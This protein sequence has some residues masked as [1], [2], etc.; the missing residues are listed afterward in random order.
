MG[1]TRSRIRAGA[2]VALVGLFVALAV[3]Q[4]RA[5]Q[6]TATFGSDH[7]V[8]SLAVHK[9]WHGENPYETRQIG[10]A[11]L[12][13][14]P[15]L[16]LLK[17]T[18]GVTP[19]GWN[20][21]Q[22]FTALSVAAV[23]I[24]LA[25]LAGSMSWR[26]VVVGALLLSSAGMLE[27]TCIGQI[28]GFVVLLV[29]L[30]WWS[31]QR[32]A[33]RLAAIWLATAICLKTT[34]LAF[35]PLLCRRGQR[36]APLMLVLG[37]LGWLCL[38]EY[39]IPAPHVTWS[40]WHALRAASAEYVDNLWNYSLS[41][42]I[43]MMLRRVTHIDLSW[44]TVHTVKL[45]M[46]VALLAASYVIYVLRQG[47]RSATVALFVTCNVCMV[48]APNIVWLH[49][50]ALLIPAFWLLL[51]EPQ[52]RLESLLALLALLCFQSTR[53]LQAQLGIPAHRSFAAGQL[54]LIAATGALLVR[55]AA[56]AR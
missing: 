9:A 19:S 5:F 36:A 47:A 51:V 29:A 45:A 12:Y 22:T 38:A 1:G 26:A 37:V 42:I 4:L 41:V 17:A 27:S 44:T 3:C 33:P 54:L 46:L 28:N 52:D 55:V 11:Y 56:R 49:H 20:A 39:L 10:W 18:A 32:R 30:F 2:A 6:A 24:A 40:F 25:V 43:P 13:P 34:P 8:Y 21:G 53:C 15:A 7:F 31:W 14:P 48:V 16:L 50:A 35:V 23:L